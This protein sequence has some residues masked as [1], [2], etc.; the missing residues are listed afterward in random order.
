LQ[1]NG[2]LIHIASK[3]LDIGRLVESTDQP[4]GLAGYIHI[5]RMAVGA[6][7]LAEIRLEEIQ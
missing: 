1:D 4:P 6:A 5:F 7:L 3:E 2:L